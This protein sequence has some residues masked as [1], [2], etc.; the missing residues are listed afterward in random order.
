MDKKTKQRVAKENNLLNAHYSKDTW[1]PEQEHEWSIA[2]DERTPALWDDQTCVCGNHK[3]CGRDSHRPEFAVD[4]ESNETIFYNKWGEIIQSDENGNVK[5]SPLEMVLALARKGYFVADMET[6][7]LELLRNQYAREHQQQRQ[8]GQAKHERVMEMF[9]SGMADA[10]RPKYRR[11]GVEGYTDTTPYEKGLE[12][13]EGMLKDWATVQLN[14]GDY[15]DIALQD[16]GVDE[17]S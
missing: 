8:N 14:P 4:P 1:T 7:S 16:L 6:W 10:C 3:W 11:V 9:F 12:V 15:I 17:I 13:G 5:P 2:E